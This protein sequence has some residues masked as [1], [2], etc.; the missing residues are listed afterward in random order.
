MGA[1]SRM[2]GA[3]QHQQRRFE[4]GREAAAVAL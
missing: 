2:P 1:V 3:G 4:R